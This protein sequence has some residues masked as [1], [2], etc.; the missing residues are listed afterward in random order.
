M[1]DFTGE[2]IWII[3]ASSGIG[4]ALAKELHEQGA[5]LFLSARTQDDLE[6]LNA[7]LGNKHHVLPLDV[8]EHHDCMHATQKIQEHG[9]TL[10]RVIFLAAIYQPMQTHALDIDKTHAILKVNLGG[11]FN[12][13]EAALPIFESQRHGQ[14]ALCGSVAGMMGLPK[15][16]PYS[17]SKAGV[18]N[19]AESLKVEAPDYLDVKVM[20]PGFVRTP[21]TDK[22]DFTMPMIIEPEDAAKAIAKGLKGKGFEIHFPKKFTYWV[23][24]LSH[25]PYCLSLPLMKRLK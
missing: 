6:S 12:V 9:V 10:D 14:L 11:A 17:A 18:I 19:L 7:E 15:G 22:N 23:K 13:T 25:L 20:N 1:G 5:T 21:M 2:Y 24:L 3:G 4:N 8:S 16:Q